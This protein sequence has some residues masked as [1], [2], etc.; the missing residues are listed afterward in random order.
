MLDVMISQT[1][2]LAHHV[3]HLLPLAGPH[4]PPASADPGTNV[5]PDPGG[6]S[7]PPFKAALFKMVQW[8]MWGALLCCVV[9]FIVI[10]ARMALQ[11]K[12]GEGGGH[13]GSMAI[14]GFATVVIMTAHQIVSSLAGGGG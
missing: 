5:V 9:G 8:G 6:S 13:V 10:G 2:A 12:R 3:S 7:E 4:D 11:H 1:A 14:V